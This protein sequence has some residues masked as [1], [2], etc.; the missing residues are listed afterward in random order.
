VDDGRDVAVASDFSHL[1]MQNL[2]GLGVKQSDIEIRDTDLFHYS[3][4]LRA[5][6]GAETVFHLAA[7]VGS[8]EYLHMVENAELIAL[9]ANLVID[10]NI[11]RACLEKGVRKL[12]YASSCAVYDMSRQFTGGAVFK[13]SEMHFLPS[14]HPEASPGVVNPDGGYGWS[15]LIGELQL[16]WMKSL[17]VG[18][19]RMFTIYGVNE[20]IEEGKAH[21]AGDIIRKVI[22]MP[23]LSTL[24]VFGDG[25]QSRDFLYVTDCADAFL[26]LE[27][28]AANPPVTVNLGSGTATGIGNL[29]SK[30]VAISGK[31]I[32]LEFDISKPMGPI[33]RTAEMTYTKKILNWEP[34]ITLEKG[35]KLTY[36]RILWELSGKGLA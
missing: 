12:V 23:S 33:S 29:A 10:A 5:V 19:A 22:K 9:Q 28:V 14:F 11:F 35:L 26:R 4:A 34:K 13:E 18:I 15:K 8:L 27:N 25:K 6:D 31:D 2:I 1:G 30:I 32:R 21:A 24:N 36:S 20:P 17:K 16:N 3:Q 7:R